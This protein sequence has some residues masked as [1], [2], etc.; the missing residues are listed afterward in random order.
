VNPLI[1]PDASSAG[2]PAA[3]S[4]PTPA[5]RELDERLFIACGL[6]WITGLI[7]AQ[8][9]IEHIDEYALYAL[10]FVV[11]A[12]TQCAWG[13]AI[14]RAPSRTLLSAGAILSLG[15]A[16]L[17]LI[18]RTSGLPIAPQPWTPEPVGALDSIA[19]GN[20]LV[21]ALL[22]FIHLR[23][24]RPGTLARVGAALTTT[25]ALGLILLSSLA[26]I[27]GHAH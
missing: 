18:T 5:T 6:A 21:L 11:L 3:S 16:A 26:F 8:A 2:T 7:H 23:Q 24:K 4:A 14:Y 12:A 20:E 25:A 10:F 17:W 9:A 15:V 13:I 19:T 27:G 1:T 22:V